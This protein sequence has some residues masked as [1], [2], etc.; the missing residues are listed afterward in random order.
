MQAPA[1]KSLCLLVLAAFTPVHGQWTAVSLHTGGADSSH[2]YA[3]GANIQGGFAPMPYP[4]LRPVIWSGTP[5]SAMALF[6]TSAGSVNAIWGDSQGGSAALG[7]CIWQ[8]TP[9]SRLDL[10]P[11]TISAV[12]AM[13]GDQ[14]AGYRNGHATLWR[15]TPSSMVDLHPSAYQQSSADATDGQYQGGWV[16]GV[17]LFH[18]ALWDGSASSFIDLHVGNGLSRVWGMAPGQQVGYFDTQGE[19]HACMWLGSAASIVDMHPGGGG[20]SQLYATI[21]NVQA[22]YIT[23]PATGGIPH[24]GIWF[25]TPNSF[26]DLH[27]FLPPGFSESAAYALYQDGDTLF[28]GGHAW[29]N[30]R[31]EGILWTGTIPAPA[32]GTMILL[33]VL[34][35]AR[36]RGKGG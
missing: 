19:T 15:G 10:A 4:Y 11:G 30:G 27:P 14:Q 3:V 7:A 25:G 32:C 24:A 22:G 36:R 34:G 23:G 1:A 8:S 33:G 12:K 16:S 35:V 20:G 18:A 21:G 2:I 6:T 26:F 5:E 17:G 31:Y 29:R 28:V 13:R 9:E